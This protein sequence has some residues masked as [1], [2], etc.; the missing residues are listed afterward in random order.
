M[1]N[2]AQIATIQTDN[3]DNNS[4]IRQA[5][6]IIEHKIRNLEKRK[7]SAKRIVCVRIV[8][9]SAFPNY[10]RSSSRRAVFRFRSFSIAAYHFCFYG[11]ILLGRKQSSERVM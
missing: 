3:V 2:V 8:E 7:V 10:F 4:P 1:I 5:L 9:N 11:F 6:V